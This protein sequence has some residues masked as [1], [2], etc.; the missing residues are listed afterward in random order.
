MLL[1]MKTDSSF[2]VPLSELRAAIG[3]AAASPGLDAVQV[4]FRSLVLGQSR[5]GSLP[6]GA[7]H[8]DP[9]RS[10]RPVPAADTAR[11]GSRRRHG[12]EPYM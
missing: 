3:S 12:R 10:P 8:H 2:D 4:R 5:E 6:V 7:G 1:Q 9:R 11:T